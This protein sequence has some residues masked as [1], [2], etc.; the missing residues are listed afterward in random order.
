M[1]SFLQFSI[2]GSERQQ[3]IEVRRELVRK[4]V[5]KRDEET[6]D[7]FFPLS[8]RIGLA[9]T[10]LGTINNSQWGRIRGVRCVDVSD[11]SVKEAGRDGR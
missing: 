6:E 3:M 5:D 1:G 4:Q 9:F 2:R 11:R 10:A 8:H 7:G